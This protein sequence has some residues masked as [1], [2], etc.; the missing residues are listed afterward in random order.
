[1]SLPTTMPAVEITAP[2]GP[3]VLRPVELPLPVL[4]EGEVLVEVAAAG[5]NR[6]DCLQRAGLY[7]VPPEASPLPGLEIAG[8]VVALG[9]GA[10]RWQLGDRVVALVH[11][12]GY[13]GYCRAHAA[14]CLPWPAGLSAVEAASLPET[15]FT[16]QYNLFMRVGL[17]AGENCLVHGGSSGI[18]ATAIQLAKAAGARVLTT[19]GSAEKLR[20][21]SELGA[22]V[23]IDYKTT[24]WLEAVLAAT[25]KRG[26]DVVLDMV[27]GPYVEKN[28]RALAPDG[29]YSMIAFLLGAKAEVNFGHV[30][31]KRLTITGSTLR[32]QSVAAKAAIAREVEDKVWPLVAAG[33]YRSPIYRTFPLAEAAAAHALMESSRHMGKIVLTL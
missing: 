22:D 30:L 31:G 20:F 2:G 13:A 23:V 12:G 7:P 4:A 6:P 27:A 26:V 5:V 1:M 24:D 16:V 28:L 10:T 21:C 33:R 8:K 19:A 32:P 25:Q 11:G 17:K 29:R 18:G 15:C 3:E 9:P 14:H